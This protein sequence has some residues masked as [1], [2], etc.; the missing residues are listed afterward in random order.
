M[1]VPLLWK[2]QH[3]SPDTF[4][5]AGTFAAALRQHLQYTPAG[6]TSVLLQ[7]GEE[8]SAYLMQPGCSGCALDRC[9][10]GCRVDLLRR[11]LATGYAESELALVRR[12]LLE[13]PYTRTVIGWP[14]ADAKPLDASVLQGWQQARLQLHW[15][16][17]RRPWPGLCASAVLCVGEGTDDPL[18]RLRAIGWQGLRVPTRFSW[19][20]GQ[21]EPAPP[22]AAR[23]WRGDP[24]LLTPLAA[25]TQWLMTRPTRD[26]ALLDLGLA[27]GYG[28]AAAIVQHLHDAGARVEMLDLLPDGWT[29]RV[30]ARTA[31]GD[32]PHPI[33][34]AL[35]APGMTPG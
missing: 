18:D 15:R 28:N 20:R 21:P 25:A 24:Y 29:A 9:V 13:R 16:L 32:D 27:V 34:E 30:A 5:N 23:A 14:N 10:P 11:V 19:W 22:L 26:G 8:Q 2:L 3:A 17:R 1:P 35:Q 7:I 6:L 12:G 33:W 4:A 31:T